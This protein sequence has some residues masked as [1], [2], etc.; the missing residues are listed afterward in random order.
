M[1]SVFNLRET[2]EWEKKKPSHLKIEG[3]LLM[4]TVCP[5]RL[6]FSGF[7]ILM[8]TPNPGKESLLGQDILLECFWFVL[9]MCTPWEG[10]MARYQRLVAVI[11]TRS[12]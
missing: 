4:G 7:G 5:S 10:S 11:G 3:G 12:N 8:G 2:K 1:W 9:I 6:S